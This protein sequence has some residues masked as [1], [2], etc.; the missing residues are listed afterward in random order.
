MNHISK[1]NLD[2]KM[3]I[4]FSKIPYLYSLNL[5]YYKWFLIRYH[6][7]AAVYFEN[8]KVFTTL[9]LNWSIYNEKNVATKFE[10]L[11]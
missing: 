7:R 1:E 11:I 3:Y 8:R 5:V 4:V 10:G 9:T 6:R 2:N